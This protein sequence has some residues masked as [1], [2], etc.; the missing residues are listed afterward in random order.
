[1]RL[2]QDFIGFGNF[3]NSN[4]SDL[5]SFYRKFYSVQCYSFARSS[6]QINSAFVVDACR[7]IFFLIAFAPFFKALVQRISAQSIAG[8][9]A[10]FLCWLCRADDLRDCFQ[11][12]EMR[13]YNIY[14]LEHQSRRQSILVLLTEYGWAIKSV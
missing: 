5:T 1:M 4:Y 12:S 8:L 2:I 14:L 13:V 9:D 10:S 3:C 6:S 7:H 11:E